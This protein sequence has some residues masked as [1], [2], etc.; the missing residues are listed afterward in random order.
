MAADGSGVLVLVPAY[1]VGNVLLTAFVFACTA[2]EIHECTEALIPV[3]VPEDW[4]KALRNLFI[5]LLILIPIGI[6]DGM[7]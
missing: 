4:K 3:A 7:F 2:H 1:P 6:S 5:F